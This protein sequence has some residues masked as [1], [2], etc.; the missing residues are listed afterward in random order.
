MPAMLSSL[1]L[2][3]GK[4]TPLQPVALGLPSIDNGVYGTEKILLKT[5]VSEDFV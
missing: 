5:Q 1:P 2:W 3:T 4:Q